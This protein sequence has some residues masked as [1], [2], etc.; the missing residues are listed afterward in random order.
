MG[1]LRDGIWTMPL[2]DP[3]DTENTKYLEAVTLIPIHPNH[4]DRYMM[5]E[6]ELTTELRD[7][8]VEFLKKNY[9]VLAWSQSGVPGVGSQVAIH[10]LFVNPDHPHVFQKR[11]KFALE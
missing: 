10:K 4:L 6:I 11:R 3:Q 1:E 8:L 5:I 2:L 9:D 7:A